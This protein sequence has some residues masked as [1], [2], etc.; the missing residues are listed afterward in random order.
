[1]AITDEDIGFLICQRLLDSATVTALVADRVRPDVLEPNET[2]PAIRYEVLNW[3]P[4]ERASGDFVEGQSRIQLDCYG[5]TRLQA[6]QLAAAVKSN[7]HGFSGSLG[8]IV[9][10]DCVMDNRYDRTDPPADGSKHW[11]KR[12][13][14]DFI[15]THTEP[16]PTL[17]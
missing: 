4:F 15:I 11:R 14:M 13:T 9:I 8:N 6:N 1:M 5:S 7:L 17:S 10:H 3:I 2:K 16:A 12:R